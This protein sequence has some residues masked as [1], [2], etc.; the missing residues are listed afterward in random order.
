MKQ[1][2]RITPQVQIVDPSGRTTR[3]GFNLFQ[4]ILDQLST[5]SGPIGTALQP[6]DI[7]VTVQAHSPILDATTAAYTA[8]KDSKLAGIAPGAT[9]NSSDAFLLARANHTGTQL[10]ATI[11]D[12]STAA[13]T[14]VSAAIG[15]T[16]QA[17]SAN[18]TA[19]ATVNPSSYLT[20]AAAAAAYQPLDADLTSWASV[21]RAAG[22]D[23]FAATPSSANFLS[24]LTTKTGTGSAVFG[25]APTISGIPVFSGIPSLTGGALSFPA[26]QVPSAGVNDLDDYEEGGWT[27]VASSTT[28]TVTTFGT[29][30]GTYTKVGNKVG[31]NIQIP[32]TTNGTG[33]G[34]LQVTGLPFTPLTSVGRWVLAGKE[35]ALNNKSVSAFIVGG[36][37]T[38]QSITFYDGTYPGANGAIIVL[39]GHYLTS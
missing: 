33:A 20:T 2:L 21:T 4:S 22:Y 7:G 31:I 29:V 39:T 34:V 32:I 12:F 37:T 15:V 24:L 3:D 38:V 5:D 19:W 36:N 25:T 18:L 6:S 11:S 26:T 1:P 8:T 17:Y 28:G 16:I 35:V 23:T 27:P 30:I 10:A 9:A 13:D 14:R